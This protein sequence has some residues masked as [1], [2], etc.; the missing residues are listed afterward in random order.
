EAIGNVLKG[1]LRVP[2]GSVLG[3]AFQ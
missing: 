1:P 3:K 2:N